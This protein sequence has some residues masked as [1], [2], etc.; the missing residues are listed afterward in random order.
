MNP[1]PCNY[2]LKEYIKNIE[3]SRGVLKM[4]DN[5]YDGN[6]FSS[7]DYADEDFFVPAGRRESVYGKLGESEE[8]QAISPIKKNTR[9]KDKKWT[10]YEEERV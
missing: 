9:E 10:K 1:S 8:R 6:Y 5:E 7:G 3:R 4:M 2:C